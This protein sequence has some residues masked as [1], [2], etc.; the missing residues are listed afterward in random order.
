MRWAA[1]LFVL[2]VLA[3][4]ARADEGPQNIPVLPCPQ[5]NSSA[6]GCNPPKHELKDAKK[7]FQKG[8]RLQKA[9]QAAEAY[10]EFT[11][12]AQLSPRNIDYVTMREM[13]RQALVSQ[14]LERGND[15]MLKNK[16]VE[17]L[18]EFQSALQLDPDNEF[19]HQRMRDALGEWAPKTPAL[20]LVVVD[21]ADSEEL[22]ITPN[23]TMNEFHYRGDARGLLTQIT[24]AYGIAADFDDSVITRQVRFDLGSTDFYSAVRAACEVTKTFWTPMTDKQ[25]LFAAD[26]PD[27]RR[28]FEGMSM[29]TFQ[30]TGPE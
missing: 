17:A 25:I 19:A 7:A 15:Q 4:L 1:L 8:L 6:P 16:Q 3:G 30:L 21:S 27:N 18:A 14:H 11:A 23:Q 5:G 10:E 9:G 28:S 22:H 20:P 13:S 24:A 2:A 12:A 26:S 29:R